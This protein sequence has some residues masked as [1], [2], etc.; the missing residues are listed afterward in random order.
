MGAG[1]A[2]RLARAG[3]E[4]TVVTPLPLLGPFLDRTYEG[5]PTRRRLAGLSAVPRK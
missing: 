5:G 1:I 2:E 4:V 3:S